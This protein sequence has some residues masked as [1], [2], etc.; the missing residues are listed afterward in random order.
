MN[1]I[2]KQNADYDA[3][4]PQYSSDELLA[5]GWPDDFD[6]ETDHTC[7]TIFKPFIE[8]QMDVLEDYDQK[9]DLKSTYVFHQHAYDAANDVKDTALALGLGSRVANNMYYATLIHDLGKSELPPEIWDIDGTPTDE[10]K[11]MKRQ[12]VD[13]GV[14]HFEDEF[15]NIE[16]PFKDLA[17][18]I[19]KH[20]HEA[21]NGHGHY[22]LTGD[23]I[24][25]P[26]RL[27]SLVEHYDGL[28]H[29]RPHQLE[30]GDKFD[31]ESLFE[32]IETRYEGHFDPTIYNAYKA[33]K[34]EAHEH[35][36]GHTHTHGDNEH[37][38]EDL[39]V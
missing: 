8:Q 38:G 5:Q 33:M 17:L 13:I 27:A 32:K 24:S 14:A 31:P 23:Q 1:K 16:H 11:A 4:P 3:I 26:A 7:Q 19:M 9:R 12:H 39:T 36:L 28:R 20:H 34:I 22:G 10:Q 18:D 6:F 15:K 35:T 2:F 30:R 25:N 29:P 21:M 37:D